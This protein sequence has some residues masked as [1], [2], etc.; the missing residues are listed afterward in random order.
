MNPNLIQKLTPH[1]IR[2]K[3]ISILGA[4][5]SG[6]AAARL[7]EFMGCHIFISDCRDSPDIHDRVSSFSHEIG[8]H[9]SAVLDADM[10]IISPGIN[11]EIEIVKSARAQGI[12]ILSEIEFASWFTED[13][14]IAITGSNGKTTT[15]YLLYAI[16]KAAGYPVM[17]GGNM[18]HPFSSIVLD[19][20]THPVKNRVIILEISSFQLEDIYFF[21]PRIAI[22]LNI[23][24]DHLN[25]YVDLMDYAKTKLK[26][27]ENLDPNAVL[28]TNL[29]DQTIQQLLTG[30][31]IPN[32]LPFI[33]EIEESVFTSGSDGIFR[34]GNQ[35]ISAVDI[36][37]T[38]LHN[39]E[40]ILAAMTAADWFGINEDSIR[41]AVCGFQGIPH[42]M[43]LV[44]DH[45]GVRYY[46]D[47][48]ATNTA[49]AVA[50]VASFPTNIILILGG[51]AKGKPDISKLVTSMAGRIKQVY[52]YGD[53][54]K[55][56]MKQVES[57]FPAKFI[58]DFIECSHSA[59]R[60]AHSGDVVLMSPACA[61]FDQFDNFEHRGDIFRNLVID[62]IGTHP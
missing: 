15:S 26:I 19:D 17:L 42:R 56:L 14:V 49:S 44:G 11:H 40:N 62:W 34:K 7:A 25:R 8:G 50:A 43:E 32:V 45:G 29:K 24:P 31:H 28:I 9:T 27:A 47:S 46:N 39:T 57:G 33:S 54:G 23:T 6:I 55:E 52:C 4:A 61:S 60:S 3:R 35:I 10:I 1:M 51:L 37:L 16:F 59:F 5:L 48:K 18:G 58:W 53:A 41:K 21:S 38:G 30:R 2:D 36:Q 13:P 20:L 12:P 22:L